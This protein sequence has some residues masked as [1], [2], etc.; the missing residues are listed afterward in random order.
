[1]HGCLTQ[2][3][4]LCF[5]KMQIIMLWLDFSLTPSLPSAWVT[6]GSIFVAICPIRSTIVFS[7]KFWF[8]LISLFSPGKLVLFPLAGKGLKRNP[9]H[10]PTF[11][12]VEI[13]LKF[14]YALS[15]LHSLIAWLLTLFTSQCKI[16]VYKYVL[17]NS[18][19]VVA[20]YQSFLYLVMQCNSGNYYFVWILKKVF[21]SRTL[22]LLTSTEYLL[23]TV[24]THWCFKLLLKSITD[25][26]KPNAK[27]TIHKLFD[28]HS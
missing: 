2:N 25:M 27:I 5:R 21:L 9:T 16:K 17:S 4:S 3:P 1:V 13:Q 22:H 15:Y 6:L 14:K 12:K 18:I 24:F 7:L 19:H 10:M 20:C 8:Y 28:D 23:Y 26:I 11:A